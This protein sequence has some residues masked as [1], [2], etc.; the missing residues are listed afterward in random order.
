MRRLFG[1]VFGRPEQRTEPK[2]E[3]SSDD[4][5]AAGWCWLDM[6]RT[7]LVA[8]SVRA[9]QRR[10]AKELCR[11][12]R[13]DRSIRDTKKEL[14]AQAER[15]L[16][17][18]LSQEERQVLA[19]SKLDAHRRS[20]LVGDALRAHSDDLALEVRGWLLEQG[21]NVSPRS[22]READL[23][24]QHWR[25]E[26]YAKNAVGE[27]ISLAFQASAGA[28]TQGGFTPGVAAETVWAMQ[29][30]LLA[31]CSQF[32]TGD[33]R[34][35]VAENVRRKILPT[36][37]RLWA[38]TEKASRLGS[39]RSGIVVERWKREEEERKIRDAGRVPDARFEVVPYSKQPNPASKSR[40]FAG[41][42]SFLSKNLHLQVPKK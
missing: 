33:L 6:E 38:R 17:E 19:G 10:E 24:L 34:R 4:A 26:P 42:R 32:S 8:K 14:K 37:I 2:V 36:L 3:E 13:Q 12:S 30:S 7:E 27:A 25:E 15:L 11:R 28:E 41:I 35:R 5:I 21:D 16:R 31:A 20:K 23:V 1:F 18:E 29:E 40:D 22:Q 39:L 9:S